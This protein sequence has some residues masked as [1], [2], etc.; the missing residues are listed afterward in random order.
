MAARSRFHRGLVLPLSLIAFVACTDANPVDPAT[1]SPA[2]EV[3]ADATAITAC[4]TV[5]GAPG[6]YLVTTN[7]ENCPGNGVVIA[8]SDVTLRLEGH[9]ISGTPQGVGI[10]IGPA[11]YGGVARVRVLGPGTVRRF[12]T[13]IMTGHMSHSTIQGLTVRFND[14]GLA[15]N[16]NFGG[17]MMPSSY[18]S[19]LNNTFTDN[20]YHGVTINGGESSVFMRN[21]STRNGAGVYNGFGFYLYDAHD[22]ELRRNEVVA[23][24]QSGIVADIQGKGNLI[25]ANVVRRNTRFDLEDWNCEGNIWRENK[26]DTAQWAGGCPTGE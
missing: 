23:N 20:L 13:G 14:H 22:I 4:G 26:Y 24:F 16:R 9:V 18:D 10:S 21:L 7:L 19:I 5:I 2:L 25:V 1:I 11:V 15:L 8:A 17:D 3:G 12:Q 6:V